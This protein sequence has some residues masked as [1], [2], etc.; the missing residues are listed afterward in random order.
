MFA[1]CGDSLQSTVTPPFSMPNTASMSS[2]LMSTG[3]QN[4]I[5]PNSFETSRSDTLVCA[6]AKRERSSFTSGLICQSQLPFFSNLVIVGSISSTGF[7]F[8]DERPSSFSRDS[9]TFFHRLSFK[10]IIPVS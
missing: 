4:F 8:A 5:M 2:P 6:L 7:S 10:F 1:N 3:S 9:A